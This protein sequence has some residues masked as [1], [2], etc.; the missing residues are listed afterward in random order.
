ML[1]P[2]GPR[3]SGPPAWREP[4]EGGDTLGAMLSCVQTV[5]SVASLSARI[6]PGF[7]L[8][9]QVLILSNER[10]GPLVIGGDPSPPVDYY[11]GDSSSLLFVRRGQPPDSLLGLRIGRD[12][13]NQHGVA[14]IVPFNRARC[15][16]TLLHETFHTFQLAKKE[17]D[18]ASFRFTGSA[19]FPDSSLDELTLLLTEGHFLESAL[20]ASS[21]SARSA[22]IGAAAAARAIRCAREFEPQCRLEQEVE[23]LEG[24]AEY[25][26]LTLL[27]SVSNRSPHISATTE[28]E[29]RLRGISVM[30]LIGRAYRFHIGAA[31]IALAAE[32]HI[33]NW[34]DLIEH[35]GVD[36]AVVALQARSSHDAKT[37][38]QSPTFVE[39]SKKLRDFSAKLLANEAARSDS[40]RR[41]FWLQ[42]GIPVRI[43]WM[44]SD[45][46]SIHT[47]SGL[48]G[49]TEF[50]LRDRS[51]NNHVQVHGPLLQT[52]CPPGLVVV[53]PLAA[54]K[55][56]VDGTSVVLPGRDSVYRGR[57]SLI[58][59]ELDLALRVADVVV[60]KDS[61]SIR[62]V[63][64]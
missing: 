20:S 27:A 24:S 49:A 54:L 51:S 12:W 21:N 37:I 18:R 11:R 34:T 31:W 44:A 50:S 52:C 23:L 35:D 45:G 33:P 14:T 15:L 32:A 64:W 7:R 4:R 6:W 42:P 63:A 36:G 29:S 26:S 48:S 62:V 57:I 2:E 5:E 22:A 46:L 56:A 58:S 1:A 17:S 3:S 10:G 38:L 16:E 13:H 47:S 30:Q 19:S 59:R 40:V 8:N 41:A 53:I 25:V 43:L 60:R 55:L 61:I 39:A 9:S 28:L